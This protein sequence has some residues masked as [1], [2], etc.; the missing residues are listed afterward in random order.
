MAFKMKGFPQQSGISPIKQNE[1]A[2]DIAGEAAGLS[3]AELGRATEGMARGEEK[4]EIEP[5]ESI[6]ILNNPELNEL[7]SNIMESDNIYLTLNTMLKDGT[8]TEEQFTNLARDNDV[9]IGAR[10]QNDAAIV[11]KGGKLPTSY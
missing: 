10:Q 9:M 1:T 7:K 2:S 6:E 5:Y 11:A 8:I 4:S 3:A